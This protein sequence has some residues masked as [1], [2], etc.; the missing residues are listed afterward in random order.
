MINRDNQDLHKINSAGIFLPAAAA[1]LAFYSSWLARKSSLK[2]RAPARP[3]LPRMKGKLDVAESYVFNWGSCNRIMIY[4]MHPCNV[5]ILSQ[6]P[7]LSLLSPMVLVC[8]IANNILHIKSQ[9]RLQKRISLWK[10]N[11]THSLHSFKLPTQ[12]QNIAGLIKMFRK[13]LLE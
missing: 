13:I 7:P 8:M 6:P 2:Y 3:I 5:H 10:S 11:N 4:L 9:S 1:E 12:T